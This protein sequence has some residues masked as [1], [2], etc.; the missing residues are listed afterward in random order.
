MPTDRIK[1]KTRLGA[2]KRFNKT[3]PNR[4]IRTLRKVKS[5]DKD[6][7]GDYTYRCTWHHRGEKPHWA[8]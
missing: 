1:G 2:S 7:N 3:W 8:K 4:V 6:R 5:V